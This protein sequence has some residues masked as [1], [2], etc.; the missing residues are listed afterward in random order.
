MASIITKEL[1][2]ATDI[3]AAL[4]VVPKSDLSKQVDALNTTLSDLVHR[5]IRKPT[6]PANLTLR[7]YIPFEQRLN[8]VEITKILQLAKKHLVDR[9]ATSYLP[10]LEPLEKSLAI[11][12]TFRIQ[13]QSGRY[14]DDVPYSEGSLIDKLKDDLG[15][16]GMPLIGNEFSTSIVECILG[17]YKNHVLKLAQAIAG[18]PFLA[19]T[20]SSNLTLSDLIKDQTASSQRSGKEAIKGR[21]AAIAIF[22]EVISQIDYLGDDAI[23][24]VPSIK[25]FLYDYSKLLDVDLIYLHQKIK[26]FPI[27]LAH[28]INIYVHLEMIKRLKANV[29]FDTTLKAIDASLPECDKFYATSFSPL[30]EGHESSIARYSAELLSAPQQEYECSLEYDRL[31]KSKLS[32]QLP[33]F[34]LELIFDRCVKA[35]TEGSFIVILEVSKNVKDSV[36]LKLLESNCPKVAQHLLTLACYHGKVAIAKEILDKYPLLDSESLSRA[37]KYACSGGQIPI[38]ELFRS[39]FS[40]FL[41]GG[42]G[43]GRALVASAERN[44]EEVIDFL[45][46]TIF[47]S[48]CPAVGRNS[49]ALAA[50][51]AIHNSSY[52]IFE[53][54]RKCVQF[55]QIPIE[56]DLRQGNILAIVEALAEATQLPLVAKVM[57]MDHFKHSLPEHIRLLLGDHCGTITGSFIFGCGQRWNPL[58]LQIIA[59]PDF[60]AIPPTGNS[61]VGAALGLASTNGSTSIVRSIMA[62]S[63]FAQIPTFGENGIAAAFYYAAGKGHLPIVNAFLESTRGDEIPLEGEFSF[64]TAWRSAV[65][66]GHLPIFLKLVSHTRYL[67][68]L[69]AEQ[70]T[71]LTQEHGAI[72][73]ALATAIRKKSVLFAQAIVN[74]EEFNHIPIAAPS[75]LIRIINDLITS[76]NFPLAIAILSSK[77]T[78]EMPNKTILAI[79]NQAL[80]SVESHP[81]AIGLLQGSGAIHIPMEGE[82]GLRSTYKIAIEKG[83]LSLFLALQENSIIKTSFLDEEY[84]LL[85]QENG[86]ITRALLM[87]AEEGHLALTMAIFEDRELFAR[88]PASGEHSLSEAFEWALQKGRL[89]IVQA[90][91]NSSRSAEIPASRRRYALALLESESSAPTNSVSRFFWNLFA[92]RPVDPAPF[93][94]RGFRA[95]E[96]S[97]SREEIDYD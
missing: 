25:K 53:K 59:S 28:H 11:P 79:W 60:E 16:E 64:L 86:G 63:K 78:G 84:S 40:S 20:L 96:R 2:D 33:P 94:L 47:F 29:A 14:I 1:L 9:Q 68:R 91:L 57:S 65:E 31:L 21:N 72:Q 35:S 17:S 73:L 8:H 54:L 97:Y 52:S 27:G 45:M 24:K 30:I 90:F 87:C 18:E 13:L 7:T 85:R 41:R 95:D 74:S 75:G 69:T 77:R 37:F 49:V 61:G 43:I 58:V 23:A 92:L 88:I 19:H 22:L 56:G 3:T 83:H 6:P 42:D 70:R 71:L 80:A 34:V 32:N 82:L 44:Q 12:T 55:R 46:Q 4:R 66:A 62:S 10:S 5:M 36:Y 39:R 89:H 93:V 15:E 48:T 50:H 67:E 81:V 26:D 76:H 38:L 51:A